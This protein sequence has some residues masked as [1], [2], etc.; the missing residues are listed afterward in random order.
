VPGL[1]ESAAGGAP[2]E[3]QYSRFLKRTKRFANYRAADFEFSGKLA[4]RRK[5]VAWPQ[6]SVGDPAAYSNA[7]ILEQSISHAK[8]PFLLLL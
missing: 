5:F 3:F 1:D 7:D 6:H 2:L 8:L 4:F